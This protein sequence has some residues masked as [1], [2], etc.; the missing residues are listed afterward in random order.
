MGNAS[1][2]SKSLRPADVF[3]EQPH[4]DAGLLNRG[5]CS[6]NRKIRFRTGV[7]VDFG[8]QREQEVGF[9]GFCRRIN[10]ATP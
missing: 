8:D 6:V 1:Y 10:R 5:W 4:D 3:Y 2:S 7:A 9:F